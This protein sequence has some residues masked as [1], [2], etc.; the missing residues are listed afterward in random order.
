MIICKYC[1]QPTVTISPITLKR[2]K[3]DTFHISGLCDVCMNEKAKFLT[4]KEASAL[5]DYVYNLPLPGKAIE[6][7]D[8]GSGQ[9]IKIMNFLYKIINA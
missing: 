7:I 9:K 1:N 6:Y 8:D 4:N 3:T 5:P 2:F